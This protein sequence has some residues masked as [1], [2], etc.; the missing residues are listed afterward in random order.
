MNT[1]ITAAQLRWDGSP[2]TNAAYKFIL[3]DETY[4]GHCLV[5]TDYLNSAMGLY[6]GS[7]RYDDAEMMEW[8]QEQEHISFETKDLIYWY[9]DWTH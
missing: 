5:P 7:P 3:E 6:V 1:S 9:I 4:T 2:L 8:V